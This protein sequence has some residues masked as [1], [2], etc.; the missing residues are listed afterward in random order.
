MWTFDRAAV[1]S[2]PFFE[3]RDLYIAVV[4]N[5]YCVPFQSHTFWKIPGKERNRRQQ[6]RIPLAHEVMSGDAPVFDACVLTF[7]ECPNVLCVPWSLC[8]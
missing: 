7:A 8:R 6:S 1:E 4:S 3:F 2:G 5:G